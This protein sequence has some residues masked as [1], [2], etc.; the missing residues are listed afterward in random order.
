MTNGMRRLSWLVRCCGLS[1]LLRRHQT[2]ISESLSS[3]FQ[4]RPQR[5]PRLSDDDR[6]RLAV[7]GPNIPWT[8]QTTSSRLEAAGP[9]SR[10]GHGAPCDNGGSTAH[11]CPS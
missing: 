5:R 2:W 3:R 11:V 9:E 4:N 8:C 6:R 7:R 1:R 10:V